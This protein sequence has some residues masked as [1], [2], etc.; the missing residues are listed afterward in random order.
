LRGPTTGR[1]DSCVPWSSET[2]PGGELLPDEAAR[3]LWAH[4]ANT[5]FTAG[6]SEENAIKIAWGGLKNAGYA[7]QS[8]GK[9]K[10]ERAHGL[11]SLS[12]DRA[13][14]SIPVVH[15]VKSGADVLAFGWGSVAIND[16]G[17]LEIDH[18]RDIIEAI[19]LENAAYDFVS[20]GRTVDEM[21]DGKSRGSLIES[22]VFSPAKRVAMG[23]DGS[24]RVGWW[25]GWRITDPGTGAKVLSGELSEFSIEYSAMRTV[26]PEDNKKALSDRPVG[27]LRQLK[28]KRLGLVNAGA[29]KGVQ[30]TLTKGNGMGLDEILA[31]LS[32]EERA[33]IQKAIAEGKNP[34][35]ATPPKALDPEMVEMKKSLD[36][37]I[38]RTKALEDAALDRQ[39]VDSA[40]SLGLEFLPGA[41]IE[42]HAKAL[43]AIDEHMPKESAAAIRGSLQTSA[44]AIRE[45]SL[46][47][48][49]G[50]P[51]GNPAGSSA[52][53]QI[54]SAV[55]SLVASNPK[56]E[57]HEAFG[58]ACSQ[59]P[60]LY[61][62]YC[63]EKDGAQ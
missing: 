13:A 18:H 23:L 27:R 41:T 24:G 17:K 55:K 50:S 7:K 16:G 49:F 37:Q 10:L 31:K 2:I 34:P 51:P 30:V 9:W 61:K 6:E 29:G 14:W 53:E 62:H 42:Q 11:K 44:K 26:L 15:S 48:S 56:L 32:P 39:Y 35:A 63:A 3:A 58:L 12:G 25:T 28:I 5:A 4:V 20:D 52:L 43:R 1:N 54:E 57:R 36:A 47:K 21:H 38:A 59:N 19:E 22:A 8:D 45:G 46:L 40:K 60:D 33:V